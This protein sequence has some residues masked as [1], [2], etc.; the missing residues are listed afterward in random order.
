MSRSEKV[1]SAFEKIGARATIQPMTRQLFQRHG[2]PFVI[3][4]RRRGD[5][6][7]Y[8]ILKT[9]NVEL[10]VLDSMARH[11]H[12]LLAASLGSDEDRFLCGH[13]EQHWFV[14]GLREAI[15]PRRMSNG[16]SKSST[17]ISCWRKSWDATIRARAAAANCSSGVACGRAGFDGSL[18]DD[19]F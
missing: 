14:A 2:T 3:D 8:E 12:L 18:R 5:G 4:V 19:Y 17:A 9:R 15:H 7:T 13:D 10:R 11:R 6:E 1:V 16:A